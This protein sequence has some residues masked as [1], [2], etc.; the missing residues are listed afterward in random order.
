MMIKKEKNMICMVKKS[1]TNDP[2]LIFCGEIE[3]K[4]GKEL[5]KR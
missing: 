2:Y 5:L 1:P 4:D 3:K